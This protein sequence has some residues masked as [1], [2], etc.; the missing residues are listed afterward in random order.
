MDNN[1]T[2]L[3]KSQAFLV[4]TLVFKEKESSDNKMTF[5]DKRLF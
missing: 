2:N 3:K 4:K 5:L 1:S